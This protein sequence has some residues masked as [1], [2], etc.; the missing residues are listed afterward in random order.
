MSTISILLFATAREAVGSSSLRR[1]IPR[2]GTSLAELL[3]SLRTEYP[4]LG[5]II[6]IS[7]IVRNGSYVAHTRIR[8]RPGDEIAI[9]PPYSGG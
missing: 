6:K 1:A 2:Q 7:R 3:E 5:P 4:R 8:I 9:H